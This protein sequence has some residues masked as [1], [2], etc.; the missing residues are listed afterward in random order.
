MKKHNTIDGFNFKNGEVYLLHA[1]DPNCP[2]DGS[3]WALISES[4][5]AAL[6]VESC[7]SNLR[8]F[9]LWK[10]LPTKY[11]YCRL[12]TREELREF[13]SNYAYYEALQSCR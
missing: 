13:I 4:D 7:S 9:T 1:N 11:K 12:A 8:T 6:R 5:E 10:P 2:S 3:L